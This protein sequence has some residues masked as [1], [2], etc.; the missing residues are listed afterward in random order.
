[1]ATH[2]DDEGFVTD[3]TGVLLHPTARNASPSGVIEPR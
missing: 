3:F 2:M 1:M